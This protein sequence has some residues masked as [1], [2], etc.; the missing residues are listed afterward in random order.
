[1]SGK[2]NRILK[3]ECIEIGRKKIYQKA[4]ML[5]YDQLSPA[6]WSQRTRNSFKIQFIRTQCDRSD[7]YKW[8]HAAQGH[9]E[10][11]QQIANDRTGAP[12]HHQQ[13]HGHR[14]G[15]LLRH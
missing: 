8:W 10:R 7:H 1:M 4:F 14:S 9:H 15:M 3:F 13:R 11:K 12:E 5:P 6:D 2:S